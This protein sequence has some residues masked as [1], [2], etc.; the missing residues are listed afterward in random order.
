MLLEGVKL[1]G[2][3]AGELCPCL[4]VQ[5]NNPL[6]RNTATSA[7][8]SIGALEG[9]TQESQLK[10]GHQPRLNS[11]REEATFGCRLRVGKEIWVLLEEPVLSNRVTRVEGRGRRKA[12]VA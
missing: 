4:G 7:E 5:E 9:R 3:L 2:G 1:R 10:W 8:R 6:L 11:I 12:A